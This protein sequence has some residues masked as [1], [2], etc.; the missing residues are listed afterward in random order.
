[1]EDQTLDFEAA[2][3]LEEGDRAKARA[4]QMARSE[5]PSVNIFDKAICLSVELRKLGTRKKVKAGAVKTDAA[6][7]MIHVSKDLLES[8]TYEDI[9]SLDGEICAYINARCLP[10][11]FRSGVYLVPLASVTEVDRKLEGFAAARARLVEKFVDEYPSRAQAAEARL[12]SLFD[13]RDYPKVEKV[14]ASFGM[15]TQY[16]SFGAPPKLREI[17]PEKY[18]REAAKLEESMT[19]AAAEIT[20]MMR[21][22]AAELTGH[23][24]DRLTPKEDGTAKVFRDSLVENVKEFIGTFKERNITEDGELAAQIDKM[25]K[26]LDGVGAKD[27]RDNNEL[28]EKVLAD[29]AAIKSALDEMMVARPTRKINFDN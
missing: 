12:G 26:V 24:I 10:S 16:L 21:A 29:T 9:T 1:M 2:R 6:E 7:E 28:R 5:A 8:K 17:N 19:N 15:A 20:N 23:L 14:R 22:A 11:L 27:L 4:D 3:R 13:P 18:A 25:R